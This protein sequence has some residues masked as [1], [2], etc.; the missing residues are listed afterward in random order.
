M[1]Q[2]VDIQNDGSFQM[3][4][5]PENFKISDNKVYIKKMGNALCII[6]FH[7]PWQDVF[8]SLEHFTAD[9]MEDRN[10]PFEQAKES[11]D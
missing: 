10:Q 3:I 5:I 9:F 8:D 6:P 11:F 2:V 1:I 4:R 7:N